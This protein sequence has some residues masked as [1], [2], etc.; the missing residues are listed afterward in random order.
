MNSKIVISEAPTHK[1]EC[2]LWDIKCD[3]LQYCWCEGGYYDSLTF[4][5]DKCPYCVAINDLKRKKNNQ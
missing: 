5:F 2:P 1:R 3:K 4:E